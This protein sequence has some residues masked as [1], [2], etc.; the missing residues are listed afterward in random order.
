MDS[1]DDHDYVVKTCLV[2]GNFTATFKNG[3]YSM[4]GKY[5][6]KVDIT[7]YR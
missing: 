4:S 3:E 7:E 6:V 5:W 1:R 2:K